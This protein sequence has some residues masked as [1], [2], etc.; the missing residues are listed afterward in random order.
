MLEIDSLK[1]K[2]FPEWSYFLLFLHK[3][4]VVL[5]SQKECLGCTPHH[6][7][8]VLA[9]TAGG[10]GVCV[11]IRFSL[12]PQVLVTV[13]IYLSLT[14]KW[15]TSA[16]QTMCLWWQRCLTLGVVYYVHCDVYITLYVT[17]LSQCKLHPKP[18]AIPK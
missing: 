18:A 10:G 3:R 11:Y 2:L 4:H 9:G 14:L 16:H 15:W 13:G 5:P 17:L 6:I 7:H 8:A 12:R 1:V